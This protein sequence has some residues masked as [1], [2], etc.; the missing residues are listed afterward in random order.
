[1]ILVGD[2]TTTEVPGS[3]PKVTVSPAAK[4]EPVIVTGVPP[5]L[6]PPFGLTADT[7]G[8]AVK[9]SEDRNAAGPDQTSWSIPG[10]L[11]A[12]AGPVGRPSAV[13]DTR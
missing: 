13:R 12:T 3:A 1:M 6:A 10:P 7:V 2:T 9:A 5:E 8:G 4:P 11:T